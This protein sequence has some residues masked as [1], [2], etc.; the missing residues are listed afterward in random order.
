M[1]EL[2]RAVGALPLAR[3]KGR[4]GE[5]NARRAERD[6]LTNP[7][8]HASMNAIS[9]TAEATDIPPPFITARNSRGRNRMREQTNHAA[10]RPRRATRV[11]HV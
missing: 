1:F 8:P 5:A 4:N 9:P 6:H 10:T 2:Y 3:T 11:A 7:V